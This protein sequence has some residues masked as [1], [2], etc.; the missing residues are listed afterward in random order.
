MNACGRGRDWGSY[1]G[2]GCRYCG[3]RG[4]RAVIEV[5]REG[6]PQVASRRGLRLEFCPLERA[7]PRVRVQGRDLA[8]L[9][10]LMEPH[11]P[12]LIDGPINEHPVP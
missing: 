8:R 1:M 7:V 11:V 3:P 5:I 6:R 2:L 12:C 9:P 10:P 4:A